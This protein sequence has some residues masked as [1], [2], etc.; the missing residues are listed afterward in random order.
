M[1]EQ[2]K[3]EKREKLLDKQLELLAEESKKT[4]MGEELLALT[5]AMCKVYEAL[6]LRGAPESINFE[7]PIKTIADALKDSLLNTNRDTPAK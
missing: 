2:S 4:S 7:A 5:C 3:W 1:N 6:S